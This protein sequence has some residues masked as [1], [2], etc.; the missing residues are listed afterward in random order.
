MT[1]IKQTKLKF[2]PVN[3]ANDRIPCS[4]TISA[5]LGFFIILFTWREY[6]INKKIIV[7]FLSIQIS[8]QK[9][10]IYVY[11]CIIS[12]LVSNSSHQQIHVLSIF[13]HILK[14]NTLNII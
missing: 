10:Y 2:F 1:Q 8:W 14:N 12:K 13:F 5:F 3:G 4:D 9:F 11:N 7:L 6:K